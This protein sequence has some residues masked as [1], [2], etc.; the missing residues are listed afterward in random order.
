MSKNS[1]DD[2]TETFVGPV[3]FAS[4]G[5]H[6]AANGEGNPDYSWPL[7]RNDTND[8]WRTAKDGEPL[9]NDAFHERFGAIEPG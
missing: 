4:D 9:H 1:K 2:Y 5:I 8:G 6:Y 7:R 3:V